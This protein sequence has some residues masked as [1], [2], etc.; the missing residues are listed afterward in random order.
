MNRKP[1]QGVINII[2]FNWHFY[3]FAIG[4]ITGLF[5][6][7]QIASEW[8]LLFD[9]FIGIILFNVLISLSVSWYVY[10]NSGLYS[11]NWLNFLNIE[12]G[13]TI[14]NINAG[15]DETSPILNHKYQPGKLTVLDFYNPLEHTEV[16]I[17][18][19]RKAYPPY[20]DTISVSTSNVGLKEKSFQYIF[21]FFAAH[22]I[23]NEV[24]QV[25]L[26]K[27][28]NQSLALDG[29]VIVLEHLRDWPNF[30]A[31]NIGFFHFYS[32]SKW[33]STF[34]KAGLSVTKTIKITP[35]LT[36]FILQNNG[37]AS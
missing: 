1:L 15:F 4:L 19:A 6:I 16:S 14:V 5:V 10:D 31:Y 13:K 21:L 34:N 8:G 23:R 12:K 24:E 30:L 18:R 32:K 36:A 11:L 27:Q 22:E 25:I 35:F 33:F 37:I 17:K 9:F 29:K 7:K 3:L 28:I 26:F 2:R 20:P